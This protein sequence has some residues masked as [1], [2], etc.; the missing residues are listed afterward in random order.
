MARRGDF[1]AAF[2]VLIQSLKSTP[3]HRYFQKPSKGVET[4]GHFLNGVKAR[5]TPKSPRFNLTRALLDKGLINL[6]GTTAMTQSNKIDNET[7]ASYKAK[8]IPDINFTLA[9]ALQANRGKFN[10]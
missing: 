1:V 9:K 10:D 5:H 8:T 7:P 2:R 6:I 3:P 4:P